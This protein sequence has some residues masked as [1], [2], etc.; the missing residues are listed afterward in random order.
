MP[1]YRI[2]VTPSPAQWWVLLA[3]GVCATGG[4]L[5]LTRGYAYA[6]AA[7][8]GPYHYT[9]VPV[10]SLLGWLWWGDVLDGW[11]MVGAT[12]IVLAGV[13]ATRR[14]GIPSTPMYGVSR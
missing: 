12:L 6:P 4:Q 13:L 9:A 11:F 8:V 10:A 14:A 3:A 5:F 1:L 2:W 7:Q